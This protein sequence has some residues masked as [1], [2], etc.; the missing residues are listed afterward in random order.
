MGKKV[1]A[2]DFG[3]SSGRAVMGDFNGEKLSLTE[4]HRFSNDPVMLGD[5]F[6]WDILRL[7]YDIKLGISKTVHTGNKDIVSIGIDTWGVDF[8]L[9]DIGG[10]LLENPVHYR[11]ERTN[12]IQ[13]EV[14]KIIPRSEFYS[15]TGIQL[16][17]F[18]TI[19]QLYYLATRRRD[20]LDRAETMLHMPDLLNFFLTGN[21]VTE[22]SIASTGQMLNPFTGGWDL[23]LIEKLN[24]PTKILNN[25]V[26]PG[27]KVGNLI[28]SICNELGAN[29]VDVYA[30]AG[31]DT[32]SAVAAVPAKA[33][34]NYAYLSCGTWSLFGIEADKPIV[35]AKSLQYNYTNEGGY[36]RKIR[37]LKNISG[38][39]L[40][41]ECRRQWA[42]EGENMSF[43]DIDK[44]T[45]KSESLK[46]FIN[47]DYAPFAFPGNMPARIADYCIKTGQT[48]PQSKGDVSRCITESLA[49]KYR[50]TLEEL[51]IIKGSKIDV[52]HIIGGGVQDKLLC[53][54]TANATK[55]T[56]VA[57][58]IEATALGNIAA[59][60]ISC[61]EF[62]SIE[63]A[64]IAIGNSFPLDIYEPQDVSAWDAAYERYLKILETE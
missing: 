10:K 27:T 60:L 20:M 47:P 5:T 7:F 36:G 52:I 18:N 17:N 61:G 13:E 41:Q 28:P 54:Y 31:H 40:M 46:R 1:L 44:L 48:A 38:L 19:F 4:L 34:E 9:L 16:M 3:A 39:W 25:I 2:F 22:Y 29:A 49:L 56:V 12:G 11:D 64:R 26:D 15:K 24:I 63:Q 33:G 37:F 21:K 51:E 42:K 32:G 23:E 58:P 57:G 50:Y 45:V 53:Q 30:V 55:K 14:F 35:N 43:K 62:S 8:G 6:Y 59:Q